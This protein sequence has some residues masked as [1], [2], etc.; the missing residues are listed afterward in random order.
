MHQQVDTV[1]ID[2]SLENGPS[3]SAPA[4]DVTALGT[5]GGATHLDG[6]DKVE[7]VI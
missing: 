2:P 3:I 1:V 6:E 4:S 5:L 7:I